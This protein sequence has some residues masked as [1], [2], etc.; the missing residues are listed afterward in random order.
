MTF[1]E[2]DW[3]RENFQAGRQN[4]SLFSY[5]V[6][7]KVHSGFSIPSAE[8]TQMNFLANPVFCVWCDRDLKKVAEELKG[9]S[10]DGEIIKKYFIAFDN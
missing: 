7:Q 1:V 5:C 4:K 2:G 3:R 6:G 9:N 10:L 8:N